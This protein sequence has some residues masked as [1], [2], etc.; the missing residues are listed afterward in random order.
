MITKISGLIVAFGLLCLSSCT[1]DVEDSPSVTYEGIEFSPVN[2][3]ILNSE[4]GKLL[5]SGINPLLGGG[6]RF[7][8]EAKEMLHFGIADISLS[9]VIFEQE[10]S[11]T[12]NGNYREIESYSYIPTDS[13]T[14]LGVSIPTDL[15][16]SVTV[17]AELGST[18]I[19]SYTFSD[20]DLPGKTDYWQ[21]GVG[22]ALWI[23]DQICYQSG[24]TETITNIDSDGN[25]S[26][27]I[28]ET[29]STWN[30]GGSPVTASVPTPGGGTESVEISSLGLTNH[31]SQ[32]LDE[33]TY[34]TVSHNV[35]GG[36]KFT[37]EHV[38]AY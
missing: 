13:N 20:D 17:Y 11:G 3:A 23:A 27:Q 37:Y 19:L 12:I 9:D 10:I 29:S 25:V 6:A 5:V 34:Q 28:K 7:E 24:K 1:W 36:D 15:L 30:W 4:S 16:D 21:I 8:I 14:F 33:I 38:H 2:G 35:I 18:Q 22:I 26:Y 31:Y 32:P